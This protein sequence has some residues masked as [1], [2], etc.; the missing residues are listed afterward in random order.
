M[1]SYPE[2]EVCVELGIAFLAY[3]PLG[4]IANAA[5]VGTKH[6]PFQ[7]VADARGISPQQAVLAWELSVADVVI[8]IPGASR[9]SSILDSAGSV[10]IELTKEELAD[11][12]ATL[13]A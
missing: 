9:P 6:R 3:S 13:D 8:P 4:G 12:A 10:E 2:I 1:S 5:D 7:Q 11:L